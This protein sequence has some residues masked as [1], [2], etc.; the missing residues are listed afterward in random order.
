MASLYQRQGSSPRIARFAAARWVRRTAR[1][2]EPAL[3][4]GE[5]TLALERV[6]LVAGPNEGA[7]IPRAVDH[8]AFGSA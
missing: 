8:G 7:Q 5:Q 1:R 4:L 3:H 2:E 6:H